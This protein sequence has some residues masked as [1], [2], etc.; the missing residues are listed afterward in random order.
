MTALADP[1]NRATRKLPAWPLYLIGA[2]PPAW[3]FWQG[4]SGNLGVD[5]V[6]VME[7]QMGLWGLWLLIASLCVTPL[8]RFAGINLIRYRRALGLLC[9]FYIVGH[10]LI[11]LVLDV[12][13]ISQIW[14]DI[15]KRPYITI[16]MI[17]F[18]LMIPLAV[19]SNNWSIRK[20]GRNWRKLHKLIYATAI[21]GAVHFILLRKGLQI[22]PILYLSAILI[23][24]GLRLVPNRRKATR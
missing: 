19:T 4:V 10:L 15:V 16:G 6:K 23:L 14:A 2:V 7:H 18:V 20:L 12:Q 22:E 21:L 24:L 11:W 17:G 1:I 9:F 13:L 8:R 5:P 3:L